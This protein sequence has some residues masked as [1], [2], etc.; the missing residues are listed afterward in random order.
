MVQ[1][2]LTSDNVCALGKQ[3]YEIAVRNVNNGDMNK[4]IQLNMVLYI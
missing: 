3:T 4:Y 1:N 2:G